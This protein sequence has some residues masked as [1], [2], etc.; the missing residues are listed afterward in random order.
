VASS[1]T[2][3]ESFD[4][5]YKDN[6]DGIDW[7]RFQRFMKPPTTSR[8]TPSWI[9]QHGYCVVLRSDMETVHF[10]CKFC[11]VHKYIAA[12]LPG[13]YLA[14][15]TTGAARHLEDMRPSHGHLRPGRAREGQQASPLRRMFNSGITVSQAIANELS[16]FN[17]QRFR[18]A[19][20]GWLVDN[21]HPLSEFEK[22]A[23]RDMIAAANPQRRRFG[24]VTTV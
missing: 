6:Y 5:E 17:I 2:A 10:V 4:R 16:N 15:A 1:H 21:N 12:G 7:S 13:V 9:Y 20:V 24:R 3:D 22:P 19:A 23:F 18:L 8:S 14:A 11:H